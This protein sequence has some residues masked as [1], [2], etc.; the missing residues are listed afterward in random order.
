MTLQIFI[1][2]MVHKVRC[3]HRISGGHR[4]RSPRIA[5]PYGY[6]GC[7]SNTI[8]VYKSVPSLK[9]NNRSFYT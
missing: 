9:N 7:G 4:E 6:L 5:L 8:V 3:R 2:N 1:N